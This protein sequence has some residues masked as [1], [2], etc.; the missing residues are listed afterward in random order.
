MG[1]GVEQPGNEERK[2]VCNRKGSLTGGVYDVDGTASGGSLA[3]KKSAVVGWIG[4]LIEDCLISGV[5]RF[6]MAPVSGSEQLIRVGVKVAWSPA[7]CE[8]RL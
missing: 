6:G 5:G 8:D 1:D 4:S 2:A 3:P 7:R